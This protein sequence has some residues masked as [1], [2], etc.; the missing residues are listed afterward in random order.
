MADGY[1]AIY[2]AVT[3]GDE[4]PIQDVLSAATFPLLDAIDEPEPTGQRTI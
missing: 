1:E 4:R 3:G 2:R